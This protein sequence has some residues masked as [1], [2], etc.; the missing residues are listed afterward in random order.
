MTGNYTFKAFYP[1]QILTGDSKSFPGPVIGYGGNLQYIGTEMLPSESDEV[2]ITVREEQVTSIYHSPPLPTEYWSRPI[3]ATNYAWTSLAGSWFGLRASGFSTT[4]V[5]DAQG[6]F[7]PYTTAPNTGHILWTKP[8]KFGGQVGA[9]FPADQESQY[10]STS[11][12]WRQFE[13]IILNGILYYV[14]YPTIE[15][16]PSSWIAVDLRTGEEVWERSCGITGDEILRCG[17]ILK[18]H[19]IQEYG[20]AAY[21]WS[22]PREGPTILRLYDANTGMHLA[23]LTGA[24]NTNFLMDFDF[25]EPMRGLSAYYGSLLGYTTTGNN[26]SMWNST[27]ALAALPASIH[28]TGIS[29]D[30]RPIGDGNYS[31]GI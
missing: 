21:L 8:T 13:P 30:L 6:S 1:G 9:P 31:A 10:E 2:T 25:D 15:L 28:R 7:D 18:H 11:I 23:N 29:R 5:F 24:T 16:K 12:L 4:G 3:Y 26:V 22:V 14:H 20:S 17:Q 19:T 27:K